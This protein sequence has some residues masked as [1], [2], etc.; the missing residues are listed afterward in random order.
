MVT[1]VQ[2]EAPVLRVHAE[3]VNPKDFD[4]PRLKK[5]LEDMKVALEKKKMGSPLP[6]LRLVFL[7]AFLW[8]HTAPLNLLRT[9][10]M[11]QICTILPQVRVPLCARN[12]LHAI[13]FLSTP[14]LPSSP[15]KKHG[16]PRVPF[17]ALALWR[18][19]TRRTRRPFAP[20]TTRQAFY[21]WWKRSYGA[22]ISARD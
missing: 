17:S 3:P 8:S 2:K 11:V 12:L 19:L 20:T 21:A 7:F 9:T 15:A 10:F 16:C 22:N 4:S 13:W 6:R 18:N 14:R 1:I 5:I